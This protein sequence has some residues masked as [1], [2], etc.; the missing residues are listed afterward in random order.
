MWDIKQ[1]G[2]AKC[3]RLKN[4]YYLN[5][6][7]YKVIEGEIVSLRLDLRYY[8]NHVGYKESAKERKLNEI[9]SII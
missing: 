9:E 6:V 1:Q 4:L 2:Q 7:G 5:H 3:E 8:L